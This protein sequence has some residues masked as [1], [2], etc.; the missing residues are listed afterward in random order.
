MRGR[1]EREEEVGVEEGSE[2]RE[3]ERERTILS[4]M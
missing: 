2:N 4:S 1:V 3:R